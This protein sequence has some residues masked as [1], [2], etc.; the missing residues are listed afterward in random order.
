MGI[1][2]HVRRVRVQKRNAAL[3]DFTDFCIA[4]GQR[5]R[6]RLRTGTHEPEPEIGYGESREPMLHPDVYHLEVRA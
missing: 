1:G 4:Q 6:A 5:I 2:H 3:S